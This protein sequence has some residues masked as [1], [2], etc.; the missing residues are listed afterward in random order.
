MIQASGVGKKSVQRRQRER[1]VV[2][3]L[4]CRERRG[5]RAL[6]GRRDQGGGL[7]RRRTYHQQLRRQRYEGTGR[8]G[9]QRDIGSRASFQAF[10]SRNLPLL[11][12]PTQTQ[13]EEIDRA[14]Q[15][16]LVIGIDSTICPEICYSLLSLG[17]C[18]VSRPS[19]GQ[20]GLL[21][22]IRDIHTSWTANSSNYSPV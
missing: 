19:A 17:I 12:R 9:A 7:P 15:S 11:H 14:Q 10:H 2:R 20:I 22:P 5:G 8:G 18:G 6:F 3:S 1:T 4:T 16:S 13:Q 21:I